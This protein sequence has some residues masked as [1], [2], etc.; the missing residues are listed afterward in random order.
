MIAHRLFIISWLLE[1]FN[2]CTG[3]LCATVC[4]MTS[5]FPART[6]W[7]Y[8][9]IDVFPT[10]WAAYRGLLITPSNYGTE[11]FRPLSYWPLHLLKDRQKNRLQK[12]LRLEEIRRVFYSHQVSRLHGIYLW[13]DVAS[14]ERG[15]KRWGAAAGTHFHPDYLVEVGFTYTA[16][17][18]VDTTW[19]DEYL[20]P[21]SIPL[22]QGNEGW[23]HSYWKGETT[24]RQNRFGSI[25]LKAEDWFMARLSG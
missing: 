19:I 9:N 15:Q 22:D 7:V 5:T 14:A 3:T 12:E 20:L 10:A 25:L 11:N 23:M 1:P 18:R 4:R 21:D 8:L 2:G 13:G 24:R 16:M 6:F 17:S